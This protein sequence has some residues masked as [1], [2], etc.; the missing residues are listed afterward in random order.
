MATK[1]EK[2]IPASLTEIAHGVWVTDD[3][4][5]RLPKQ[6][7]EA[8]PT[9]GP[10]KHVRL[11]DDHRMWALSNGAPRDDSWGDGDVLEAAVLLDAVA[12]KKVAAFLDL[13]MDEPGRL[14][15][16]AEIVARAPNAFASAFAIAGSINGLRKP[17][18]RT[19]RPYPFSWWEGRDGSETCY[20]MRQSTARVF[21]QARTWRASR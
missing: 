11:D 8:E 17:I 13:L 7:A 10:D 3:V 19:G 5:A 4:L 16:T 15:T 2:P 14:F 20:A 9:S 18:E 21:V 1:E 12:D 6:R